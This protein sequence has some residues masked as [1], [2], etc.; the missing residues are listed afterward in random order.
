MKFIINHDDPRKTLSM[1]Q[2]SL[3]LVETK[4]AG[5][6]HMYHSLAA[7]IQLYESIEEIPEEKES[8]EE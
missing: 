4:G 1:I 2:N 3:L 6:E 5:I 8:V 7:I